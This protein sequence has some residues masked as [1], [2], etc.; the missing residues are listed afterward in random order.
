M[1]YTRN[2]RRLEDLSTDFVRMSNEELLVSIADL[3]GYYYSMAWVDDSSSI[4]RP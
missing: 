3:H 2:R 1:D 4:A